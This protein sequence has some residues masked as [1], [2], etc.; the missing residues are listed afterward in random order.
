VIDF[1]LSE[2][3]EALQRSARDFLTRECPPAL[4]R[5]AARRP[6]GLPHALYARMSELGW[7]GILVP[8]AAGGLGL[9][10]LELALVLEE[11]GRAA[12]PG[13]FLG[14]Q[15]VTAALV[16]AGSAAQR[17]RW[18]P[19]L[20]AGEVHGALAHL[21]ESDRHDPAG[22]TLRARRTRGGFRLDGTKLFVTGVPGAALLLVAARNG[23]GTGARGVSL[24]L[25][26]A[27]ASGVRTRP[28]ET[29]DLTRRVGEVELRGAG[30][31][32]LGPV[33]AGW[34]LLAR[35]LDLAAVGIASSSGG[36]SAPSRP[37]STWRPRWW[38]T[39]SRPA[40]SS[41]T[42]PGPS[43]TARARRRGRRRSPRRGS[44]PCTAPP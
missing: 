39:S 25:V 27:A 11:L 2:E 1:G 23:T 24:F 20:L 12:A 31:E 30:G 42:P 15:L 40:R 37:S 18:L 10:T 16:R 41:G 28:L 21:E 26:E 38:P 35:L 22:V 19:R 33:G 36:R 44:A 43:T 34:P 17:R 13:P 5:E 6:D 14:T 32:P 8:E 7:T 9:G 29:I 4:V 3:Q